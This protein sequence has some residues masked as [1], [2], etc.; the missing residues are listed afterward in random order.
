MR[1]QGIAVGELRDGV[2]GNSD[3]G[4]ELEARFPPCTDVS[5]AG[6]G[7]ATGEG[8]PMNAVRIDC[9]CPT[10][11]LREGLCHSGLLTE[12]EG[13]TGVP[14]SGPSVKIGLLPLL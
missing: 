6:S 4:V 5:V 7:R 2:V 13:R 12:M 11:L 9:R 1:A 10:P 8:H 14:F 3:A